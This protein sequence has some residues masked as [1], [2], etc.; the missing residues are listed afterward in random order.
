MS[1]SL[2][3][4]GLKMNRRSPQDSACTGGNTMQ[5][6]TTVTLSLF[7]LVSLVTPLAHAQFFAVCGSG[8]EAELKENIK[9][10]SEHTYRLDEKF[11]KIYYRQA[12]LPSDVSLANL[13][14]VLKFLGR[15]ETRKAAI[16]FHA[17]RNGQLCTWLISAS[18]V[19]CHTAQLGEQAFV[20]LRPNLMNALNVTGVENKR[21]PVKRGVKRT[22]VTPSPTDLK[23]VLEETSQR[24]L[25]EPILRALLG[26]KIDTLVVVPISTI[27]TLPFATFPV[28]NKVL[29]D[30]LS[31][32]IAPGFFIFRNE[33]KRSQYDFSDPIIVGDPQ[34][35]RDPVWDFP[36]LPGARAEAE[37]VAAFLKS[38]ALIGPEASKRK[39]E[40]KLG[41]K[42][43]TG[44]IYLATHG[45]ADMTNPRD[46]SFLL[47]SDGRWPASEIQNVPLRESKPLVVMSACQTGLG[48]DFDV[49]TI[50]MTRAWHRAGASSV[51]MSLWSVDDAATRK[52]MVNFIELA[53]E[54][55]PDKALQEAMQATR[56]VHPDPTLWAGFSVFGVPEVW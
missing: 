47:L 20:S 34:G 49:G 24:L 26:E 40:A 7:L 11:V 22:D 10:H 30:L 12:R 23:R 52:L 5:I 8:S 41:P 39:I 14:D 32:V 9:A 1:E 43:K 48:K 3:S 53:K 56:K 15:L 27:G 6:L 51:V 38:Q 45:I 18:R 31:V 42:P 19:H 29:M 13:D 50:G 17:Y 35:W 21:A 25:P 28:G 33:P 4:L 44:L 36:P 46:S 16:L 54:K 2:R 55:P 37:E